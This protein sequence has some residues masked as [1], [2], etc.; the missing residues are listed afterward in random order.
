MYVEATM[1]VKWE[2][3]IKIFMLAFRLLIPGQS[4]ILTNMVITDTYYGHWLSECKTWGRSSRYI[5][6][7]WINDG[8][9]LPDYNF[10][11]D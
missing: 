3:N 6:E 5:I 1:C 4:S 10:D 9:V 2:L 7:L 11:Q 8:L